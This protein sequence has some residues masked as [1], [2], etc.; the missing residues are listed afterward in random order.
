VAQERQSDRDSIPDAAN[1]GLVIALHEWHKKDKAIA[2]Q[3]QTPQ[4]AVLRS[5]CLSGNGK[6][7]LFEAGLGVR[8]SLVNGICI[9]NW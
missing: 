4:K 3:F 1:V 2:I 8:F 6:T 5:H 9:Y 7:K